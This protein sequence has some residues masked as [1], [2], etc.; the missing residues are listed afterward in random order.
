[1]LSLAVL[2]TPSLTSLSHAF[3]PPAFPS[4]IELMKLQQQKSNFFSFP[5]LSIEP[6]KGRDGKAQLGKKVDVTTSLGSTSSTLK[7]PNYRTKG[8]YM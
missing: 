1:M 3:S 4:T 7:L 5:N 2:I 6:V 8:S